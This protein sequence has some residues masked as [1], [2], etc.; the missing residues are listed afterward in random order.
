MIWPE[1]TSKTAPLIWYHSVSDMALSK[2]DAFYLE[3]ILNHMF[4][5]TS[6]NQPNM[7]PQP[8]FWKLKRLRS[9][10]W[11]YIHLDSWQPL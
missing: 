2:D 6:E 3:E 11:L 4:F 10:F 5:P 7:S 1:K 8:E 9:D